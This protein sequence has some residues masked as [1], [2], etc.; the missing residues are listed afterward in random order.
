MIIDQVN[1]GGS[2]ARNRGIKAAKGEYI[3]FLDAD[4]TLNPDAISQQMIQRDT[5]NE[6]ET[7]FGDFNFM[8]QAGEITASN[9]FSEQ[10]QLTADPITFFLTSWTVLISC[11]LH[12]TKTLQDIGG[13]DENLSSG[14][15]SDLHMR[16]AL[17][18]VKFV[19]GPG[20][21]FNYRSHLGDDR[22]SIKR[23]NRKKNIEARIYL[24]E[25]RIKSIQDSVGSLNPAQKKYFSQS[26]FGYARSFFFQGK[27]AEGQEYLKLSGKYARMGFP[28]Y[29][30]KAVFGL[31]Y[32]TLGRFFG[33]CR[34][35][36][37]LSRRR[38][39]DKKKSGDLDMLFRQ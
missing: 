35:E 38:N 17:A 34:L 19:H 28:P 14:Q 7:I 1:Q 29:K 21:I 16:L 2:V 31:L 3:K 24:L 11:P 39:K 22:I 27:K 30:G 8:N 4:D 18:G 10:F 6:G 9:T 26:Y 33:F 20:I 32:I 15:E 13:F 12:K 23:R 36:T 5:L 25:K 37:F